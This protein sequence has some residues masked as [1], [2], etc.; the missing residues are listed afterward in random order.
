M[1]SLYDVEEDGDECID[2]GKRCDSGAAF[3]LTD[4]VVPDAG[5][6]RNLP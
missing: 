2:P 4:S 6:R 1:Y 5:I 3:S